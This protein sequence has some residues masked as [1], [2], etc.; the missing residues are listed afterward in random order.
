MTSCEWE[1]ERHNGR[2]AEREPGVGEHRVSE[3]GRLHPGPIDVEVA[4]TGA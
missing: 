4:E 3:G 2:R 1:D